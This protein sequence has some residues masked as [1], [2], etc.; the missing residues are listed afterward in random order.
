MGGIIKPRG[1]GLSTE[2]GVLGAYFMRTYPG[3]TSIF[4]SR[5]QGGI[6]TIFKDKFM[7]VFDNMPPEIR[8]NI[9]N[10]NDT[11]ATCYLRV[12]IPIHGVDGSGTNIAESEVYLRETSES[13]SSPNNLS[14]KGALFGAYD[15]FPLH[16]RRRELLRSSIECYKDPVT[17]ELTGFLL[18]GGTVE[19]SLTS[20]QTNQFRSLVNDASLWD[21]D[22]L[23]IPFWMQMFLTNGRPDKA[24]AESGG[25]ENTTN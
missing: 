11:K 17:K 14:G 1:V 24:K 16:P 7:P 3:S 5:D 6:Q 12:G 15:E 2:F 13:P 20:E 10:K 23:F 25:T 9:I 19:A 18:W 4:T 8:P 22:V 21:C